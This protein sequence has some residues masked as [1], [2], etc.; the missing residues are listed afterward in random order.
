M[1]ALAEENFNKLA[2]V[3]MFLACVYAKRQT[4]NRIENLN[5]AV[6][7]YQVAV[8]LMNPRRESTLWASVV[9]Q[10]GKA[11]ADSQ[12]LSGSPPVDVDSLRHLLR[13]AIGVFR[14]NNCLEER[15]EASR[16][17]KRLSVKNGD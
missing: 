10:L 16:Y 13:M 1:R 5:Q 7:H 3:N 2:L 9:T 12:M 8:K 6:V 15:G 4:G 17:L 11:C 14:R